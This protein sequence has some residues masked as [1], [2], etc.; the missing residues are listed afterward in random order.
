[1]CIHTYTEDLWRQTQLLDKKSSGFPMAHLISNDSRYIH[2]PVQ[3]IPYGMAGMGGKQAEAAVGLLGCLSEFDNEGGGLGS[4][5][6]ERWTWLDAVAS[7]HRWGVRH[8]HLQ[9]NTWHSVPALTCATQ[10]THL[11]QAPVLHCHRSCGWLDVWEWLQWAPPFSQLPLQWLCLSAWA[12]S[13][14]VCILG[15]ILLLMWC[16]R[17]RGIGTWCYSS[18][19]VL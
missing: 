11:L 9:K 4:S 2:I 14:A 15:S 13:V 10:K 16:C 7:Q 12:I 18:I 5:S 3:Y 19:N 8:T 1:M 6:G 17:G